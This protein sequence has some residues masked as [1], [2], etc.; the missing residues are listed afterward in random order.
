MSLFRL[1]KGGIMLK[2]NKTKN[3]IW[4][5]L[6]ILFSLLISGCMA[7]D[8]DYV[9]RVTANPGLEYNGSYMVVTSGGQ[10]I[11][12]SVDGIGGGPD[13]PIEY[14]VKGNIVSVA[15]QKKGEQ[16]TLIVEILKNEKVVASSSTQAAYGGLILRKNNS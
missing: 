10:S 14:S 12:K 9:I 11:S 13:K 16:G 8:S 6:I 7:T 1:K 4:I 2:S 15:F 3:G 5:L